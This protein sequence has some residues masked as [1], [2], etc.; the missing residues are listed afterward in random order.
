MVEAMCDQVLN[1]WTDRWDSLIK[2]TVI[3]KWVNWIINI[4]E[5]DGFTYPVRAKLARY[6]INKSATWRS[7]TVEFAGN[8]GGP[9]KPSTNGKSSPKTVPVRWNKYFYKIYYFMS[10]ILN[11]FRNI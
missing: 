3:L 6:C 8:N 1:Q 5:Y 7:W 9:G 10:W 2:N 11:L 4:F